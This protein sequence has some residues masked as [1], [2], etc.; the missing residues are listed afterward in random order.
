MHTVYEEKGCERT[1]IW[2]G[3]GAE[4]VWRECWR[5]GGHEKASAWGKNV[6]VSHALKSVK[7]KRNKAA[8][9]LME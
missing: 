5:A 6:C 9:S 1:E 2:D 3:G 4:K 7:V 8:G